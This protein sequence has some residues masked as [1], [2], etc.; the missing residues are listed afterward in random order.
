[1]TSN[2]L[3]YFQGPPLEE[4]D[5]VY[6]LRAALQSGNLK[7]VNG[8]F[9][10]NSGERYAIISGSL[11]PDSKIR[12]RYAFTLPITV[13]AWRRIGFKTSFGGE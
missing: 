8:S 11:L 6:D 5:A 1:M 7:I 4:D 12:Y 3:Y 2:Y 13:L 10:K 9:V